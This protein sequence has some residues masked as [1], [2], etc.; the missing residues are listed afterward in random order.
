[1]DDPN[2][3][4]KMTS[5]AS[6]VVFQRPEG[7]KFNLDVPI[8]CH[9]RTAV[10]NRTDPTLLSICYGFA[11][12]NAEVHSDAVSQSDEKFEVA[13]IRAR[14]RVASCCCVIVS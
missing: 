12:T 9:A 14:S 2:R 3:P 4:E 5:N 11:R 8:A 7:F 10:A 6:A 13:R 1:M